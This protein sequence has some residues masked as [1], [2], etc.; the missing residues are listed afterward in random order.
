MPERKGGTQF[1]RDFLGAYPISSVGFLAT[2][3][4]WGDVIKSAPEL[5]S[6]PCEIAHFTDEGKFLDALGRLLKAKVN[7][8]VIT[9]GGGEAMAAIGD[10][11][12]VAK[13]LIETGLPFYTALGHSGDNMLLDK[14]ADESFV[15]PAD[16]AH[17][18]SRTQKEMQKQAILKVEN[19][20]LESQVQQF[21]AQLDQRDGDVMVNNRLYLEAKQRLEVVQ[22]DCERKAWLLKLWVR[23]SII[24]AI[25]V[26][27]LLWWLKH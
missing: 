27:L 18:L 25:T 7:A 15:S 24:L 5:I 12:N 26:A 23:A 2:Q 13:A 19:D 6:C 11:P 9:R 3:L 17:R 22:K 14:H 1:L 21:R 4:A 10:S 8:I 20:V 16:V